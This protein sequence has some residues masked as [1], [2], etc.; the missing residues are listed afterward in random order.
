M[1]YEIDGNMRNFG[2]VDSM[3]VG[4]GQ[5]RCLRSTSMGSHEW[6]RRILAGEGFLI[7]VVDG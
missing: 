2:G 7:L 5:I 1:A 6:S 3:K 4:D